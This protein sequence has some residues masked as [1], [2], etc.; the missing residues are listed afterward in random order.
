MPKRDVEGRR[1]E[2]PPLLRLDKEAGWEGE[3]DVTPDVRAKRKSWI[4]AWVR[5]MIQFAMVV[6][7]LKT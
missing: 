6:F 7:E 3:R 4:A 5:R 2:L 1:P